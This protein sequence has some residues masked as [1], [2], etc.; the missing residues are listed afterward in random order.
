MRVTDFYDRHPISE[1]QVRAAVAR[2][3]GGDLRELTAGDQLYAFFVGLVEA[4]KLG[5]GHF[6]A[7]R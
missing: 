3:R 6:T 4:G 7:S 1:Q 5:G 2:R